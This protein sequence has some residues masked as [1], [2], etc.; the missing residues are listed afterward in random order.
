MD[1]NELKRLF[2]EKRPGGWDDIP[3]ID[4]YKDQVI[5]Y[6]QRQH[7][8]SDAG[9]SVTPAMINNYVK[10]KVMPKPEGKR[11]SREHIASLTMIVLLKQIVS[12]S[13]VKTL[14]DLLSGGDSLRPLYE[15]FLAD[16]DEE[17]SKTNELIGADL[18]VEELSELALRL[19]VSSYADKLACECI[20]D[21]L[22]GENDGKSKDKNK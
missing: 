6:M 2:A 16:L 19:A 9:D 22:S 15:M 1:I 8:G 12:V 5:G 7:I 17:L 4:L 3:D 20:I 11:Y 21:I 13:D 14:V 10:Q 18:S